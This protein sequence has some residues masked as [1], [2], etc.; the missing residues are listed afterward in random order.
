MSLILKSRRFHNK[1]F[2][3]FYPTPTRTIVPHVSKLLETIG[4]RVRTIR[5]DK[6]LTRRELSAL[7]GVSERYLAQLETGKGNISL[8]RFVDVAQALDTEP[9]ELLRGILK[10]KTTRISLLGVRGAGKSSVGSRLARA[11]SIS[12]VE[13]DKHIE[14]RAGLS[15]S[16]L[17]DLHGEPYYRRLEREVLE[18]LLHSSES[19]VLATGGS[20]VNHQENYSLLE[21]YTTT[22]W[23]RATADDHWNR[24][25][26][27]GDK[28]P[29]Q[30][31]PHA[32]AELCTLLE[33]R[34]KQYQNANHTIETSS[35]SVD[36][37]VQAITD[38]V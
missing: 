31:N 3:S 36:Q 9:S 20:I 16:Q 14:N 27:Q 35:V 24:V 6:D 12:F 30:E 37:V 7:C 13:V 25:I 17:F 32:F 15:L 23:L 22:I 18:E 29:M 8:K 26:K 10:S 38:V 5:D 19:M 2:I 33:T 28:R 4:A 1:H 11:L 34:T 21:T